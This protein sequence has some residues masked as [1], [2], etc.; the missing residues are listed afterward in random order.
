MRHAEK[1]RYRYRGASMGKDECM[2][3]P[4]ATPKLDGQRVA[5]RGRVLPEQHARASAQAAEHGLSLS[6]YLG[7]LIDRD[8]GLPNKIDNPQEALI[9]RAS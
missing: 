9:P 8:S 1:T 7:A 6:E 4:Y 2:S 3:Q 5:L